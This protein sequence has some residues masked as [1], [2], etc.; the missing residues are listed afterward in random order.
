MVHLYSLT[1]DHYFLTS[2]IVNL[3]ENIFSYKGEYHVCLHGS[4]FLE[5]YV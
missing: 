5:V 2:V 3:T 1:L 4:R